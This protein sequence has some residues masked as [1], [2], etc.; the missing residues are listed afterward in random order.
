[1]RVL[2]YALLGALAVAML[3]GLG[4][5]GAP[6]ASPKAPAEPPTA[7]SPDQQV[8]DLVEAYRAL[9][10]EDKI[11]AEGDRILERLHMVRGKL[12]PR[13]QEAAARLEASQALRG[14]AQALQKNDQEALK[15]LVSKKRERETLAYRLTEALPYVEPSSRRWEY[16][17]LS[18]SYIEKLG[19]GELAAG[20]GQLGEE[21]WELVGFEKGRFVVKRQK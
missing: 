19:E 20:L 7:P 9:P 3:T 12:S 21:G 18:E 11:G 6:P 16:K 17:I 4:A 1:M 10:A 2:R 8:A 14:L 13:S 5:D 15:D